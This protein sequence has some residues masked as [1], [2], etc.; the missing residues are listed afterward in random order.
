MLFWT[1]KLASSCAPCHDATEQAI[2]A[3]GYEAGCDSHGRPIASDHPW[4]SR[5]NGTGG[6]GSV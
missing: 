5:R 4:N 6:E 3:K 2:E 1:G